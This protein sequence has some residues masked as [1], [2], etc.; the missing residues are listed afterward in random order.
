MSNNQRI[1]D[2]HRAQVPPAVIVA[3]L[4]I[5]KS[6][7]Y[8]VINH[9]RVERKLRGPPKNKKLTEKFLQ[10]VTKA[11]EA[12]PTT[13]I[14][15][16]AKKLRI[17]EKSLR[18]GLKKIGKRSLVRPPVP[19]LTERLKESRFER[20]KRLLSRIK[21]ETESTV[22]IFSDKKIFTVDQAY[23]RRND[24][25]IVDQGDSAVP[26]NRTK[27]PASI[28]VLGI[29][30]SDG[31]K[32]PPI[33]VPAG[34]KVNTDEYL[35]LLSDFF[36]P[37]V[38]KNYPRGNYVFQQDGAPAHTARR[39]QDWL[40]TNL[41]D[42]WPKDLWP[43]SSPDLNPLD[44]SIWGVLEAKACKTSHNSVDDLK[45]SIVRAWKALSKAYI[46]KTCRVFRTRLEKVIEMEGALFEKL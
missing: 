27:H 13:S 8:R 43:P 7:V 45:A 25:M 37:W 5:P 12:A 32:C 15:A 17:D 16:H 38:K 11:V 34:V 4:N 39:T 24:R 21:K 29:V 41:A 18:T 14:R 44:Y 31:K 20:S 28:M 6:T 36:L 10:R 1:L 23:N 22:R 3:T 9:G 26:V 35:R 46:V 40:A 19:L 2:L 33:F 30:A 42:F